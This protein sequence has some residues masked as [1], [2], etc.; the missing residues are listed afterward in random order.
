MKKDA[1][2]FPHFSNARND[3]KLLKLRRILGIEGYGIYFMLLEVLRDQTDFKLPLASIDD[4]EFEFRI[5]KE[6]ILAVVTNFQLFEIIDDK[7]FSPKM[8]L[9]L[10]PY[11][12]KT[13][14]ARLAAN[15]RWY[16]IRNDANADANAYTNAYASK[17]KE[18][19]V[20]KVNKES[21]VFTPP[22][23]DEVIKFFD[24]NG[25][26]NGDKAWNYYN[27]G[28]WK[29]SNG[30]QVINWKQKMRIVWFKEE[31]KKKIDE[32]E[33]IKQANRERFEME[34]IKLLNS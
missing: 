16:S 10:Q 20:N 27:D 33:K 12:E 5:S 18:S 15:K 6:K 31:N 19:K 21:K 25:Y 32:L 13:E 24:E 4:L 9:Y 23:I 28:E 2:Y 8:M 11:L 14:R 3:A 7:F 1:Y 17:G 22:S 26:I 34:R 29:D 30:K